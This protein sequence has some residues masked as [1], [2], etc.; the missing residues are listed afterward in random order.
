M[1]PPD[2]ELSPVEEPTTAQNQ[3]GRVD[4]PN[5]S[6]P[7]ANATTST[8]YVSALVRW[9]RERAAAK[10]AAAAGKVTP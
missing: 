6:T 7:V 8:P 10:R 1:Q 3:P 2:A 9:R 4:N 5:D